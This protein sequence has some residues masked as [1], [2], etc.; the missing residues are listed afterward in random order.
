VFDI[1]FGELVL[2][3]IVGLI[4]LGPEKLPHVIYSVIKCT[5]TMKRMIES[6]KNELYQEIKLKELQKDLKKAEVMGMENLTSDLQSSVE[7]L[8]K[9]AL[10]VQQPYSTVYKN[11]KG[12]QSPLNTDSKKTDILFHK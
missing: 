5:Q 1:G 2:I 12:T 8:K 9:A 4:V 11:K 3:F 10:D 6:T 7:C